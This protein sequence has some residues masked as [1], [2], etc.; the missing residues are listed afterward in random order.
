[1]FLTS[2]SLMVAALK[3]ASPVLIMLSVDMFSQPLSRLV[4]PITATESVRQVH[5]HHP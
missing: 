1:M 5:A 2:A 4:Q 3:P